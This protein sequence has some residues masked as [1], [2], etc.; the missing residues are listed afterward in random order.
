MLIRCALVTGLTL[1][2]VI[3]GRVLRPGPPSSTRETTQASQVIDLLNRYSFEDP[4][5][6]AASLRGAPGL[7]LLG[8]DLERVSADWIAAR[9]TREVPQRRLVVATFALEVAAAG[10]GS[11]WTAV[12]PLIE[13]GCRLVRRDTRG[14]DAE[15]L[16]FLA[17]IA[18]GQGAVDRAADEHLSHA[19]ERFPDDPR[20]RLAAAIAVAQRS[21][22]EADR[23]EAWRSKDQLLVQSKAGDRS[24]PAGL[25]VWAMV[26][27]AI[28][29]FE[30]LLDVPELRAEANLRAGYLWFVLHEHEKAQARF[31]LALQASPDRFLTYLAHFLSGRTH[32]AAA[33]PR[34]AETAYRRAI[35]AVPYA[36]AATSALAV[37]LFLDGRPD[38]AYALVDASFSARPRPADPWRAY[39][40]GD[41][42]FW[43]DLMR[44]LRQL[45]K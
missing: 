22:H 12:R 6:V 2:V 39:G 7:G 37:R 35:E 11:E 27:A 25:V 26:T 36:Q 21:P 38:E 33:E 43:P 19:R 40:Y 28:D 17:S 16:W 34:Q 42:R 1:A 32:D 8:K 3:G 10:L 18:L 5:A 24:A 20:L 30:A 41:F 9:G 29:Q 45:V 23:D 31:R 4:E 13:F 15:R 44:R 14:S